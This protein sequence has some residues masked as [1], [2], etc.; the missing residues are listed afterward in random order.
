MEIILLGKR[1]ACEN[2]QVFAAYDTLTV[3]PANFIRSYKVEFLGFDQ[4]A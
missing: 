3:T 4:S 2:K 1:Q